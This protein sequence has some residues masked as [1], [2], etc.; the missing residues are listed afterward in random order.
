SLHGGPQ[1][2]G[3]S[4]SWADCAPNGGAVV[5]YATPVGSV[6][7]TND[8]SKWN[9]NQW[10]NFDPNLFAGVFNSADATTNGY[11]YIC[12]AYVGNCATAVVPDWQVHFTTDA[13]QQSQ[14]KYVILSVGFAAT[15]SSVTV[16][17][18][19]HPLV[20]HGF[21]LKNADAAVRSGLSGTFQW[22]VF[23]WD[24]SQLNPPGQDN[25]ITL[26]VGRT[27]GVMY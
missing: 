25:V 11:Q 24:T 17:L 20:W 10:H 7:A 13:P 5:Y 19:G 27:Q 1:Q 26:N 18:N 14:G 4:K 8:L 22:V 12:P 21:N 6:P 2:C 15:E 3:N 9:Y 16:S 23:Q